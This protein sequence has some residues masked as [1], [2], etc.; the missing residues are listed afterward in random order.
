MPEQGFHVLSVK[1]QK[2]DPIIKEG[3]DK[4]YLQ[5]DSPGEEAQHRDK[6]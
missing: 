6:I 2:N 5:K 3:E 4:D 1:K